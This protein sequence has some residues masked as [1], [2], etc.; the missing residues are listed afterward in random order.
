MNS[1]T[2]PVYNNEEIIDEMVNRYISVFSVI[3]DACE[4]VFVDV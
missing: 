1:N 2:I 3:E 4:F